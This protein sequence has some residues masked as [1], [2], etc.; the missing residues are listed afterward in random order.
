MFTKNV[1]RHCGYGC[2]DLDLTNTL[3]SL[4]LT[5]PKNVERPHSTYLSF[6]L[7][8]L[9]YREYRAGGSRYEVVNG[10]VV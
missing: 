8:G 4:S 2:T 5:H 6:S 7:D 3:P 1:D 9:S 10:C